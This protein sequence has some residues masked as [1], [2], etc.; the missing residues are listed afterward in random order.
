MSSTEIK[1]FIDD[2]VDFYENA[3]T[4]NFKNYNSIIETLKLSRNQ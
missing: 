3:I 4:K 2:K 1:Y